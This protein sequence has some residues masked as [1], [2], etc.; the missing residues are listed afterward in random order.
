MNFIFTNI[1]SPLHIDDIREIYNKYEVVSLEQFP[2]FAA[3]D[4]DVNTY[5]LLAYESERLLGY[6]CVKIRKGVLAWVSFGPLVREMKE[7]ELLCHG[8][9][10]HC[11][12][13]GVLVLRIMPPYLSETDIETLNSSKKFKFEQSE[14]DFNWATLKLPLDKSLEEILKGFSSNH[15]QSIKK[16]QKLNFIVEVISDPSDIEVFADQYIRMYESRNLA[17]SPELTRLFFKR[18]F[19]FYNEHH[20]GV[21]I[22]V[23]T[24]EYGIIGGLCISYQGDSGFYQKGYSDPEHRSLPINHIAMYE[25]IKLSKENGKKFFDFGG[26]GL[27]LKENDQVHAINRFKSWFG[28]DLVYHPKTLIIYTTPFSKV[29]YNLYRKFRKE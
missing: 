26:Y 2:G 19:A 8:L 24:S 20:T 6:A 18:L 23:R 28:G 29:L 25:A 22:T 11:R 17:I 7:Y 21:F 12:R 4:A 15:R 14:N 5:Y 3:I 10:T 9:V 13:M 27:N 16:A 1:L